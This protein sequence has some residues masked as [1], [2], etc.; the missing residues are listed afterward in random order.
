MKLS[1]HSLFNEEIRSKTIVSYL[2]EIDSNKDSFSFL[3][4]DNELLGDNDDDETV[5]IHRK[6]PRFV[7][8]LIKQSFHW[9]LMIHV[10]NTSRNVAGLR[11]SS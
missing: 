8:C 7:R 11:V 10:M 9:L 1:Y 4:S 2:S 5:S 3:I 6:S